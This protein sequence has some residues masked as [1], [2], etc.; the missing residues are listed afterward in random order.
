M[1]AGTS[2]LK[3]TLFRAHIQPSDL[4]S[5]QRPDFVMSVLPTGKQTQRF[6][7]F[8]P[9]SFFS[10]GYFHGFLGTSKR[11]RMAL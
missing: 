4:L 3:K 11:V 1:F 10:H 5:C 6:I 9:A 7:F 2:G 8:F